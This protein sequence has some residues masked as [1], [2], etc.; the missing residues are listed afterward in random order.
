MTDPTKQAARK[1][2]VLAKGLA[3]AQALE[4]VMNGPG[5]PEPPSRDKVQK[6]RAWLDEVD[7]VVKSFDA[8]TYGT[9][10]ECRNPIPEIELDELPW[11][12]RC[13]ACGV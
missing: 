4:K 8:G 1:K 6:L 7:R 3:I 2:A 9:C 13:A 10:R 11:R 5:M 12:S